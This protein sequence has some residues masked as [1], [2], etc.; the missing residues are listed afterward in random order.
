MYGYQPALSNEIF[1]RVKI[2]VS[3]LLRK[4][5][6]ASGNMMPSYSGRGRGGMRGRGMR[7]RGRYG[8]GFRGRAMKDMKLQPGFRGKKGNFGVYHSKFDEAAIAKA[9]NV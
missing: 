2:N 5:R 4:H 1:E 6:N 8:M 7:G 9:S 3:A